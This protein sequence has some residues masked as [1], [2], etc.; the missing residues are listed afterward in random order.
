MGQNSEYLILNCYYTNGVL[1]SYGDIEVKMSAFEELDDMKRTNEFISR[2]FDKP[3]IDLD[4]FP[5][6]YTEGVEDSV[7]VTGIGFTGTIN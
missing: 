6:V 7:G 3:I 2:A 4:N 1:N 5:N